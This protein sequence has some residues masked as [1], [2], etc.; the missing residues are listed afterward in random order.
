MQIEIM[1]T[2]RATMMTIWPIERPHQPFYDD[3]TIDIVAK[4]PVASL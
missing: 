2:A 1:T 4:H 3:F